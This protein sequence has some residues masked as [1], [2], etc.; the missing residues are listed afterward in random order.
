MS[1]ST[2]I[3]L[4]QILNEAVYSVPPDM[5]LGEV[6]RQ[7][8][9]RRI[10]C[11]VVLD[12]L[13][14][15]GI[16]T[17]HDS[18][19][20]MARGERHAES[21]IR[22]FMHEPVLIT[23]LTMDHHRAYQIMAARNARHLVAVDERGN[24]LGL[25]TEGDL[26]HSIGMEQMVQPKIVADAMT[27]QVVTLQEQ[28]NLSMAARS[29]AE[30]MLSCIVVARGQKPVGILSERDVVR[31]FRESVNPDGVLLAQV[32]SQ[33]LHTVRS[34]ELL[35]VAMHLMETG[36]I[37]RLVVVDEKS[38]LVGLLTRH[39]IVKT[40][41]EQ[42][43]DMLQDTIERLERDLHITR[44][45]LES[46]EH[47]LLQRSVMDQVND[48]VLVVELDT[49][50]VVEANELAHEFLDY[51]HEELLGLRCH[52]FTEL[53]PD[54]TAWHAWTETLAARGM[55][56]VETRFHRREGSWF[57]VEVSL[58][59][60]RGGGRAFVVAVAR[61]ITQRKQ[62][63]ARIRMDREQ[64]A[65]LR[66][67]LEIGIGD[68][69]LAE[70]LGRCLDRLLT[71]SWLTLL[72]KAGIFDMPAD[73]KGLRLIVAHHLPTELQTLCARVASGHCLCG[74]AAESGVTQFANCLDHRHDIAY[75][76]MAEHGHYSLP[77]RSGAEILGV[78]VLYLPHHHPRLQEE[79]D[80]LEAVADA[81]ASLLRRDRVESALAES[82]N[83]LI[84]AESQAHLGFW[85][86]DLRSGT[87]YWADEIYR[88]LDLEPTRRAG[89]DTLR[90]RVHPDDWPALSAS[91][92]SAGEKGVDHHAGYRIVRP[93]GELRF[94]DCR[95]RLERDTEG[96]P[97][98]LA[99]TFQDVTELRR[100][101]ARLRESEAQ[102]R[103]LLDS[104]AEAIFGV[105]VA[106][107]CTFVNRS[108]LDLL[109]YAEAEELLGKP[110]HNLIHHHYAD[111]TPYPAEGCKALP[112]QLKGSRVH[113]D[114][115]VFWRKDG[116]ALPVE[117]WSHPI[118]RHGRVEGA[119]VTFLDITQRRQ[120]E[121]NLRLAAK[122][123]ENTQEGVMITDGENRILS[124]N[125]AF[126]AITGYTETEV[127]GQRP[128]LL[129]SGRHDAE[130]YRSLWASLVE[131][132]T[133][134]GEIWN[135]S[136]TGEVYPEWLAISTVYDERGH[137]A[138]YVG[139]FSD[140]SQIKHSEAKLE[141]LA[142]HDPLTDLPNRSL[143]QSRLGHAIHVAQ[144][145]NQRI[146]L[147]FLD[148]DGFK[149]IND[150]LGHPAGDELLQAIAR[151]LTEHLRAVDTLARLG[152][153]EFVVLLENLRDSREAAIVAQNVLSLLLKP[154]RLETGQEVFIGASIG[155]SLFP[156]D[157]E[158]ATQLVRNA[159]AAL[160]QAKGQGRNTYR[161]YTEALTRSANERL[162]LESSL[163]RA[164]EN[165]EFVLH[166]QPQI[167]LRDGRLIG[168][169]ALVRW[170]P[171]E[172]GAL[173]PPNQ[174]IPL[175]EETG[176]I[177]PLGEWVLRTAC[178]Q[179][180][181][182]RD[183]GLPAVTLAVNLS[184]RQFEQRDLAARIIDILAQTGYPADRLE[185][186]IT[187]SAI[188]AQGELAIDTL[189]QVKRLG[190]SLSIDD[191]GT[192]YSSLAYLKRFAVD[193]LKI[194]QSFI[195]DIPHND[196]DKEIAATI[197][198]M[199]R[200]MKLHV[201]AEGVETEE[202]H[203]F[204]KLHGCDAFQGFL[205]SPPLTADEFEK[206]LSGMP[207]T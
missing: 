197:I 196:N 14:P 29:M 82:R 11:V 34:G 85:W 123:F 203:A 95:G 24:L 13:R 166:Y 185:L 193:K 107:R 9:E 137:V 54:E 124:V 10:S 106:D 43:V 21:P 113:V 108:C 199:A 135:R 48:A 58:R 104:T 93:D 76:G 1:G 62:D 172:G 134:Q 110:I 88:I 114:D 192:G 154:F 202:Q 141:H 180:R 47:R 12:G 198:A 94:V 55:R 130:F 91:L 179:F 128:S 120:S 145:H 98:R 81:L 5:S 73:G 71:V 44:D 187:E 143:F 171:G 153:D 163:R 121:E 52:D 101:E 170:Q 118:L 174:F 168:A 27:R 46:V 157:A 177:R 195:R 173:I 132:G 149:N 78:L 75:P 151:R 111:G 70:R 15:V 80:F 79:Q 122:V 49:G 39:D 6:L 127:I 142:H 3:T 155:I 68:G 33:P 40:L 147:L 152:G 160:Y 97:T 83:R 201:L 25:V 190:V 32:M 140:I 84:Q 144:R 20:L 42:Y 158:D 50:R 41:Q 56:V 146:G 165:N 67:I 189:E 23:R 86:L 159:D 186:E 72:P 176:L 178:A 45:R 148:M 7:M 51:S 100:A 169:E 2:N 18:V 133:W 117:Y 116:T 206:L 175:A 200:N 164:L 103:L 167:S 65:V 60:V 183:A 28:D 129:N 66:E 125:K 126:T 61:D 17:E 57:P 53:F 191:F 87:A 92:S 182:W 90:E 8:S 205:H 64:Q 37:R 131:Q 119:V 4:R 89:P 138:N 35:A 162:H 161:F 204:L 38:A 69:A 188:M 207:S 139:V 74:R 105:D 150:S 109:G 136:K 96:A 31:L 16:F 22:E 181:A 194:D 30:R 112:S 63:E 156:D 77:L 184:T 59:L 102:I 99:G 19:D 26:L 36:D 115:E